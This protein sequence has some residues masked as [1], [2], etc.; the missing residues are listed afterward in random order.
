M[1]ILASMHSLPHRILLA[2]GM[3]LFLPVEIAAQ[4][5]QEV[6]FTSSD[7]ALDLGEA[8]S[9]QKYP[10]YD[11]YVQMMQDYAT[12]YP[13]ICR[14]DTFGTSVEGRLLL[15]LKISDNV[16]M[17]EAE[18]SFLY[19]STM[20]GDEI[21]GF[22][23]LLRLADTLLKGYGSDNEIT[24]LVDQ[25]QIWINPLANP[26]GSYTNDDNLSL[27]HSFRDNVNGV[28]LNRNFPVPNRNEADDPTGRQPE[29]R[30]MMRF[31]QEH[32]FSL[33][34][35][36][37]SGMEVVNYPWDDRPDPHVDS[38]WYRFVAGEYAD[39]A[40]AVDPD[41]M[42]GWPEGGI[43]HGYSWYQATGTRQDYINYYLGGREVTL[44]LSM[45]KKLES[46][47]LERH[48]NLNQRSLINYL[49]QSTFGIRGTVTD[50]DSHEPLQARIEVLNH[51]QDHD[52]SQ[53]Y[54]SARHGDFYRFLKEG[55]YD[56]LITANGYF[57]QTI[58]NVAVVD[59]QATYLNVEMESW[60]SGANPRE[61][62][63]FRL[64]PNPSSGLISI[65]PVNLPPGQLVV[66]ILSLEGK[67]L[68]SKQFT[69][70]GEALVMDLGQL[71][72]G[73]YLVQ[74][75]MHSYRKLH[76]LLVIGP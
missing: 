72:N 44:E 5:I 16:A 42:F 35:N 22:V 43:V 31:M 28:D 76:R 70:Q 67:L 25:L 51:D 10:T 23:L 1:S 3:I 15:A 40:M 39:E 11:Q 62:P 36:I 7:M 47:E 38:T 41:Y 6:Q 59:Y 17:D 69:W 14:L 48:W 60:P 34:A 75:S 54:S 45:V 32:R 2:F 68:I 74:S 21:V 29:T 19:T 71:E 55:D 52:R 57:D 64:Y 12:A 24:G 49:S 9:F 30:H 27:Q 66:S 18:A 63:E 50:R 4:Q 33:A 73:L 53:V 37:H 20:H 8:K 56:L 46:E 13:S 61:I 26:D 65:E 58:P